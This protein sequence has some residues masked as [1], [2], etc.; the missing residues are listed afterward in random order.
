MTILLKEN[1]I[2]SKT[3][4]GVKILA[5][6]FNPGRD[7]LTEY[8]KYVKDNAGDG[9]TNILVELDDNG[10]VNLHYTEHNMPFERI[11]R[12]T[13][14]LTGDLKTWNDAK[15]AEEHDRLKHF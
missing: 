14:Y 15:K 6:G 2:I 9:V 7:E 11:R 4:D 12:I 10:E 5:S 1:G 13:G 3:L 8:V